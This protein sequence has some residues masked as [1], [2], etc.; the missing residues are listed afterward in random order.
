MKLHNRKKS[1]LLRFYWVVV[2]DYA[3]II[4]AKY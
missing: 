1:D 2:L 3:Q 4:A